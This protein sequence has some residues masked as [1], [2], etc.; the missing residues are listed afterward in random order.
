M[1]PSSPTA[2]WSSCWTSARPSTEEVDLAVITRDVVEHFREESARSCS[3]LLI[4]TEPLVIGRWDRIRLEQVIT[5]LL[6]NALK[7]GSRK[8]VE[9]SVTSE[10]GTALLSVKDH[11]IGIAPDKL[12]HIFERFE[13][14]VSAREYG[15][16]GLGLYIAHEIVSALGGT[17]HVQSTPGV[18]TCFTVRLPCS[19]PPD[20][21][22]SAQHAAGHA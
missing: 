17:V 9:I 5:N 7:F 20:S 16:L 21:G 10:H 12:P 11:G 22:V 4:H 3:P 19:R 18:G 6:A 8:P 1:F 15:G 14:A 13:R 2:A